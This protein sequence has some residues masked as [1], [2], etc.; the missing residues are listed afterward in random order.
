MSALGNPQESSEPAVSSDRFQKNGMWAAPP[1]PW[2]GETPERT[3]M[4]RQALEHLASALVDLPDNQRAV[5]TLRDIEGLDSGEVCNILEISET[6][7]RVLLHRGRSRLRRALEK[8][9]EGA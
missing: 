7:Q 2:E 9:M 6:N 5:V 3:A 1:N 8:H 4:S